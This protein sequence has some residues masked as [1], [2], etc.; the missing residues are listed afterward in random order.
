MASKKVPWLAIARKGIEAVKGQ[1]LQ[2]KTA[3][4]SQLISQSLLRDSAMQF[5]FEISV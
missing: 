4:V 3:Q 2:G 1:E 5:D